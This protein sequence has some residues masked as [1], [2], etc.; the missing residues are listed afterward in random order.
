MAGFSIKHQYLRYFRFITG[1]SDSSRVGFTEKTDF[2]N[3][4]STQPALYCYHLSQIE[5][6]TI[7]ALWKIL[8]TG[9][10]TTTTA[11]SNL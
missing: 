5:C 10:E 6:L 8:I 9:N 4:E 2:I 7:C 11:R 1:A 3:N